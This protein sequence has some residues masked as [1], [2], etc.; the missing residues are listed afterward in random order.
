MD[1]LC[2]ALSSTKMQLDDIIDQVYSFENAEEAIQ[3]L[4]EG[5]VVGK[6]VIRVGT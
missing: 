5:K 3:R 6:L 2:A 4:W 1:D